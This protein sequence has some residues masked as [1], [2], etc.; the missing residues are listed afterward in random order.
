MEVTNIF[1]DNQS[2]MKLPKNLVFHDQ[3]VSVTLV[4]L[5]PVIKYAFTKSVRGLKV[6]FYH[7]TRFSE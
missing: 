3:S 4:C 1:C 7:V 6:K 5:S 2:C